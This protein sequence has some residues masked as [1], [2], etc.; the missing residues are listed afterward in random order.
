MH[1]PPTTE[2]GLQR[3]PDI[4]CFQGSSELLV[5]FSSMCTHHVAG[6][7]CTLQRAVPRSI[8]P[9]FL[10]ETTRTVFCTACANIAPL[11]WSWFHI[12]F[13]VCAADCGL[14]GV[15][16]MRY[17]SATERSHHHRDII[18]IQASFW[19]ST[20]FESAINTPEDPDCVVPKSVVCVC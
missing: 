13:P 16:L 17:S 3:R 7:D 1:W 18:T 19:K 6:L 20:L 15:Y 9:D 14:S 2:C 8:N 11:C 12:T 4:G 10:E 5:S